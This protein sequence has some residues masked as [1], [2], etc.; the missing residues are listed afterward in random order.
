MLLFTGSNCIHRISSFLMS[1]IC[2]L[3][4][5]TFINLSFF[6]YWLTVYYANASSLCLHINCSVNLVD[7]HNLELSLTEWKH[8]HVPVTCHIPAFRGN[9]TDFHCKCLWFQMLNFW[10]S[11]YS[12]HIAALGSPRIINSRPGSIFK[13]RDHSK[14]VDLLSNRIPVRDCIVLHFKTTK[15]SFQLAHPWHRGAQS[16]AV[17]PALQVGFAACGGWML[18]AALKPAQCI[19]ALTCSCCCK[20]RFHTLWLGVD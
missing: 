5:S 7:S 1:S 16:W 18:N 20:C 17:H 8:C 2:P 14:D 9:G 10:L 4:E 11:E 6:Y 13:R 19:S 3:T 12:P 15:D